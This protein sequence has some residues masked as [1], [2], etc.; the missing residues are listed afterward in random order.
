MRFDPTTHT[1]H[2]NGRS[3]QADPRC[4]SIEDRRFVTVPN[5]VSYDRRCL[6]RFESGWAASIMW[7]S[8]TYSSNHDAFHDRTGH[9]II[10][11]PATVEV[12]VLDRTGELRMRRHRDDDGG[13]WHDV[14]AYLDDVGLAALLDELE[15]MPTDHDFGAVPPTIHE[16]YDAARAAG[17]DVPEPP[18]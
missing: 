12:G 14:E 16:V 8:G 4:T 7:G 18:P 13:E 17:L 3:W 2:A 1:V 9:P 10:E 11:E 15:A 6:V 5:Y